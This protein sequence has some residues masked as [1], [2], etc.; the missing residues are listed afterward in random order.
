MYALDNTLLHLPGWKRFKHI[1][2]NQKVSARAINQTKIRQVRRSDTFQ[3]GH[4]VPR[5]YTHAL[6]IDKSNGNSKWYD[7]TQLEMNQIHDYQVLKDY[8]K[9]KLCP[10]NRQATNGFKIY[11]QIRVRLIFAVKH[12]GRHKT[13][14]VAGGHLTPEPVESI[15]S[16]VVSL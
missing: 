4:L 10:K 14:L 9:A 1:A 16:G 5:D 6:E 13:R 8:G 3:F 15:Y 11:Q 12:D 7:A 2:K